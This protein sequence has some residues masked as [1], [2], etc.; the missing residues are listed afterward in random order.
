VK[1]AGP[2]PE[3]F[4]CEPMEEPIGVTGGLIVMA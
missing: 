1:S 2:S 4:V 3:I